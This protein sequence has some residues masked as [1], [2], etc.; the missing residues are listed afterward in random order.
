[1]SYAF[2]FPGQGSQAV[3]MGKDL[4]DQF[5]EARQVFEEVDEALG[6]SL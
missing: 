3:L 6:Q 5:P 1:M 2:T 4:A